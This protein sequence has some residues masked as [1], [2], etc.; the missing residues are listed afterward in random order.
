M[1]LWQSGVTWL[2]QSFAFST[3]RESWR[4]RLIALVLV[5]TLAALA[6]LTWTGG[7]VVRLE[8]RTVTV[9]FRGLLGAWA[10]WGL[11]ALV[12]LARGNVKL[13]GPVLFYDMVR[14]ARR[15]RYIL[16][17]AAY[18]VVL[19]LILF[20]VWM[21][22]AA[23]QLRE[24]QIAARLAQDFF[25]L[26]TVTQLIAV[27]LLTP[28]YV[29]GS[30]SE[31][32]DR[33]TLEF[34]LATD[35]RNREIVFSKYLSRLANLMLFLLTGLPILGML[36][37]LG[38]VDPNLV[39]ASFAFTML[40]MI[41]IGGLSIFNSVI[42]KRPRD[43]I[44]ITY[45]LLLA[46]IGLSTALFQ[47]H[48]P[49]IFARGTP[50]A[51]W[52]EQL[53]EFIYSGNIFVLLA[54]VYEAGSRGVLATSLPGL[55]LE[56]ALFYGGIALLCVAWATLRLRRIAL[57]QSFGEVSRT[58][59]SVGRPP[60][61]EL[62]ML[63]KEIHVEG[64]LKLN[65]MARIVLGLLVLATFANPFIYLVEYSLRWSWS[66]S[67]SQQELPHVMNL[68]ARIAGTL[69]ASLTILGV[70]IRASNSISSER[71]RQTI[72]G[73]LTTPLDSSAILSA[74]FLGSL[75][76]VR[77]GWVWL[78][79]IYTIALITGG[80]NVFAF[81]LVVAAWFVYACAAAVIGMWYSMVARSTM[82][83]TVLTV[84]TCAGLGV[85][86]WLVTLLGLVP[87]LLL[88]GGGGEG[89][90]YLLKFQAGM[91]PPAVLFVLAFQGM[92][93]RAE[94]GDA[95]LMT[96]FIAFSMFGLFL[97]A[98]ATLFFWNGVLV[99]KF[100]VLTGRDEALDSESQPR[101]R[102]VKPPPIP[103]DSSVEPSMHED[104][105]GVRETVQQAP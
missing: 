42:Y 59:K 28:A 97:T 46:Y 102:R 33:Q 21:T 88:T 49:S 104:G 61:T 65:W 34:L 100:R 85:G 16:M 13:F 12:I 25:E 92:E 72:D 44:A 54:K 81:P 9:P 43:S 47:Y 98:L 29:A 26:F 11:L 63:W 30:I 80:L 10:L 23:H 38:G 41:G 50:P 76:S 22:T 73:L 32:K 84:M 36:Q 31:E 37:F 58:L 99:P 69:I 2:R 94:F 91:T 60:V 90:V 55:L 95:R 56:Y 27:M 45:L 82:R 5:V 75:F 1:S 101:G 24:D 74:K 64:S 4:E 96:E 103:V 78:G 68:W 86:H 6:Y 18:C 89:G 8:H 62:P 20:F 77:L 15:S 14:S 87:V 66:G 105:S 39:M 40:T 19:L 52:E 71:D 35:L 79:L 7:V 53:Y 57:K 17:R 48:P 93:F 51:T 70:S 3:S 83:A 67:V